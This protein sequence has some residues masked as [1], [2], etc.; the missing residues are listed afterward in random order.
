MLFVILAWV[1][2]A[3]MTLVVLGFCAYELTWKLKRLRVD[4][5][6]LQGTIRDLSAMQVELQHLQLRAGE[7]AAPAPTPRGD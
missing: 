5:D 2:A 3:L 1:A 6:R 7:L 4:A